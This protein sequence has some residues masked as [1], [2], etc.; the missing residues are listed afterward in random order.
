MFYG[1]FHRA[2]L[3]VKEGVIY[4]CVG[5]LGLSPEGVERSYAILD[6][7]SVT[8]KSLESGRELVKYNI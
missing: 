7:H 5:A 1:H 4:V 6:E 2:M 3:E 8:V